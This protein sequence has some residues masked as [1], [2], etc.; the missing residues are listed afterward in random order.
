MGSL[1]M[2]SLLK[3]LI[4][5]AG[6]AVLFASPAQSATV[7]ISTDDPVAALPV[8][9]PTTTSGIVLTPVTGSVPSLRRSPW[10][11]V[12]GLEN[13]A[14]TSISGGAWAS[15][16]FGSVMNSLTFMWGS[17]DLYNSIEFYNNGNKLNETVVGQ[18]A[19][20]AGAT[21]GADF[22]IATVLTNGLFDEIRFL[23]D[24]NAFEIANIEVSAVPL[25]AALPLYGAGMALMGFLGWRKR[26]AAASA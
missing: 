24:T 1:I 9:A 10:D 22:I 12:S 19:I 21:E 16:V 7:S 17:V 8:L 25:P 13:S 15:Y 4:C 18:D 23:S 11:T 2:K 14:Y 26:K 20:T 6:A 3:T 5:V